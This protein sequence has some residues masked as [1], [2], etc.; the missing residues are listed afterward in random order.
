MSRRDDFKQNGVPENESRIA[1]RISIDQQFQSRLVENR[2]L[3]VYVIEIYI[4]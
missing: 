1:G 2:N 4:V 3:Y